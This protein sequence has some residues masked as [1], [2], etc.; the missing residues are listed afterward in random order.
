MTPAGPESLPAAVQAQTWRAVRI[1]VPYERSDLPDGAPPVR[2]YAFQGTGFLLVRGLLR[3]TGYVVTCAHILHN[4][5]ERYGP[6]APVRAVLESGH[7]RP[8]QVLDIDDTHDLA[9]LQL[10]G[11][12]AGQK[13]VPPAAAAVRQLAGRAVY[14]LGYAEAD[15]RGLWT[16]AGTVVQRGRYAPAL[17]GVA[18]GEG[19]EA[20]T[21]PALILEGMTPQPGTSGSPVFD[22]GGML[23]GYVK[24]SLTDGRALA[25][26]IDRAWEL[27]GGT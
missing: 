22:A 3:L 7:A 11:A 12:L 17:G 10:G 20:L 25:L 21:A 2:A 4:I 16:A 5:R 19:N 6:D 9:V 18:P 1:T 26:S 15:T 14:A 8:L 13:D 24:G 27:L 23:V